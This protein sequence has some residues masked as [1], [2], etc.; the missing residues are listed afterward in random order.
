VDLFV[1]LLDLLGAS[2]DGLGIDLDRNLAGVGEP[3]LKRK[4]GLQ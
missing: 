2:V 4:I 3:L 1:L